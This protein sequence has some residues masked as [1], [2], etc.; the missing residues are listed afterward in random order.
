M[1]HGCPSPA[2]SLSW[3]AAFREH[4][5]Q[6]LTREQ[7]LEFPRGKPSPALDRSIDI[8]V[9]RVRRKIEKDPKDPV[10][11]QTVRSGGY[12]LTAEVSFA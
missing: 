2:A 10:L 6:V 3:L 11:I 1:A 8:Q 12:V 4:A 7:L 5:N 9:S